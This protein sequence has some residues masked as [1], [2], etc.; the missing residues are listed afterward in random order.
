MSSITAQQTK[1]DLELV[2]KENRLDIRKFMLDKKKR[3]KFTLEVF[4]DIFQICPRVQ[5]RD[6]DAFP[7]EEDTVSFLRE[8]SHTGEI[9]SLNDVVV[10][11]MHQPWRTFAALINRPTMKESKAYKTFL[12]YATGA[13]PP[14]IARKFKKASPSKKDSNLVHVDG[15]P[16]IKGKRVKR[17][18]KK[19]STKPATGIVIRKTPVETKFKR[20]EEVD[21]T[22]GKGIDLLSKVALT[23][24]AQMKEVRKKSLKDFYKTHHSGSGTVVKKPPRVDK[25]TL[26]VISEG[27]GDKLGVPDVT[28]DDSTKSNEEE[29]KSDDDKTPSNSE[30]GSDS[31]QDMNGSESDSE[32]N[33]Q[34]YKEEVKDN[35]EEDDDDK[36]EGDEDRGMDDTTNQFSDDVQDKEADVERTN[37]QQ[38]KENLEIT[39]E[40][41]VED[42][43]DPLHTQVTA[44]VDDHLDTRMGATR[45][46]FMNFLSAS[47]TDRIIEQVKN[48][49]PQNLPEEVSNF[50]PLVIDKM[51]EESLNQV[52]LAKV[53]SQP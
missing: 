35:D 14:K 16:V 8:L 52:N 9:N 7:S 30:K 24:E 51:I 37:V 19:S 49:L 48:Y 4:R 50:A 31:E 27:T 29:N 12:G 11:Q 43:H 47:L 45:E 3:F 38:E 41:V 40:Q 53:P 1:L 34:E 15:E 42:A 28:K 36:F 25:I 10:D 6:F 23:K 13:V 26:S 32:S 18:F 46:E 21:V 17:S 5:G 44:L 39:Q 20:K 22:R 33:Q 2:P